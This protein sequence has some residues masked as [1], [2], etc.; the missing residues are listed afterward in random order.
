MGS[1]IFIIVIFMV[2]VSLNKNSNMSSTMNWNV[3]DRLAKLDFTNIKRISSS[4]LTT[5]YTAIR[6][7]ENY[8]ISFFQKKGMLDSVDVDTLYVKMESMHFHNGLLIGLYRV[9]EDVRRYAKQYD[10]EVA[11]IGNLNVEYMNNGRYDIIRKTENINIVNTYRSSNEDKIINNSINYSNFDEF[12]N[13]PIKEKSKGT[14]LISN[15]FK[16][17]TRL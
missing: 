4:S 10:I 15:L 5:Y 16:K 1:I 13:S 11:A 14:S 6:N 9:S 8:I 2:V 17:P 12:D 7:G 3:V